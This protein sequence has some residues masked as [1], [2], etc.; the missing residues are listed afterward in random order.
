VH[1]IRVLHQHRQVTQNHHQYQILL[2]KLQRYQNP[3]AHRIQCQHQ[4]RYLKV[5]QIRVLHQHQQVT[6][7]QLQAQVVLVKA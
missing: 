5:H 2:V 1:Q 6:Q 4:G 3:Q 7:N